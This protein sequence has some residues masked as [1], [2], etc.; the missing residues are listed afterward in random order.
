MLHVSVYK[1]LRQKGYIILLTM[2]CFIVDNPYQT[3]LTSTLSKACVND[4]VTLDCT[5]NANPPAHEYRFYLNDQLAHTSISGVYQLNVPQAGNNTYTCEPK[6][7]VGSG[8]NATTFISSK[9]M[10]EV[11]L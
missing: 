6:N 9:G 4:S 7:T 1:S 8:Q 5:T 10:A 11:A 2:M 3:N